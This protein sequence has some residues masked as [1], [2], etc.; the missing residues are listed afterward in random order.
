MTITEKSDSLPSD[1][2]ETA[3][4]HHK[5][6]DSSQSEEDIQAARARILEQQEL[7]KTEPP[8][9][10]ITTLFRGK[11]FHPQ[12]EEI[13]TQQSV[14]DDP[15]LAKYFQ[16]TEKYENLHRFDPSARWTWAEELVRSKVDMP[17][18]KLTH[19]TAFDQ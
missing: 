3:V 19:H 14:Y 12:L 17:S 9:L 5:A 6:A 13:A 8:V 4:A 15:A 11:K 18:L 7:Q 2:P 10:P 1:K 16:P